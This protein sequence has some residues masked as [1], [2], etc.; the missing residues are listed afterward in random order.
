[1]L[2]GSIIDKV[3]GTGAAIN[4][5]LGFVPAKV[6][7]MNVTSGRTMT[8]YANMP[9]GASGGGLVGGIGVTAAF[10]A[11]S[12][13]I[14]PYDSGP[15]GTGFGFTIGTDAINTSTQVMVFEASR[16]GPGARF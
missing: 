8:W 15:S 16:S 14:S 7:L 12:A 6:S 11:S 2:P 9:S 10:V 5:V 3:T 1:M 13:G 4:V